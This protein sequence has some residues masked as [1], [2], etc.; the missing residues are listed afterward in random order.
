MGSLPRPMAIKSVMPSRAA[1]CPLGI[2]IVCLEL[3]EQEME[4]RVE[5]VALGIA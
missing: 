1:W 4:Q 2:V 5:T 3:N